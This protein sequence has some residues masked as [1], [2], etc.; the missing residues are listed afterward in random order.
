[1]NDR[2][3]EADDLCSG[4]DRFIANECGDTMGF[5][6]AAVGGNL[7]IVN[8]AALACLLRAITL[9]VHLY[10]ETVEIYFY[11]SFTSNFLSEF[12]WKAIGVVQ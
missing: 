7:G 5:H 3:I 9:L 1:M 12:E 8:F 10:T 4:L 11:F 6:N 2:F